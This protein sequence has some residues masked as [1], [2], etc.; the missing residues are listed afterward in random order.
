MSKTKRRAYF[1]VFAL[2]FVVVTP[3]VIFYAM[4]Y[5]FGFIDTLNITERGGV[6]VHSSIP[7]TEI[8]LNDELKDTTGIFNQEYL[9]QNIKP[10]RYTVRATHE[11]Y[12]TWEK[13]V[14]VS[15][16]RV[17][18]LYPFL[19]PKEFEFEEVP[20]TVEEVA[21]GTTTSAEIPNSVYEQ[22]SEL[23][24]VE[25]A[26][27]TPV[28]TPDIDDS[29]QEEQG[30]QEQEVIRRVFGDV[31][32][33]YEESTQ[34]F[35]A[36]WLARGDFLPS[37]FCENGNCINPFAFLEVNSPVVHFDFYPGR[38][39]VILFVVEGGGVY[40]VEIDKRPQ[41]TLI[42]IYTGN[43]GQVDFELAGRDTLVIQDGEAILTTELDR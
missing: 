11:D 31:Q 23:F 1:V 34:T 27:S 30:D 39:D 2:L 42:E 6:Y 37:Y 3:L 13:Y 14:E 36:E 26:T 32:V 20:E 4:G 19:A 9:S 7:G 25:S 40:A 33:W 29:L 21:A 38:D 18:S 15:P 5:R 35:Y 17:T 8:Y 41:Q 10:G 24:V 16:Q 28:D 12:R 43:E 22:F